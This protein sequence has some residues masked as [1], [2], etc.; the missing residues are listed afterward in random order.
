MV[1][2]TTGTATF[3]GASGQRY[4]V[5]VY[6]ADVVTTAVKFNSQGTAAATSPAYVQFGE[7]VMWYDLSLLPVSFAATTALIPTS[8][9]V[10]IPQKN[11]ST[12]DHI[13][14]IPTRAPVGVPYKAGSLIG[15]I[16]A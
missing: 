5:S 15:A 6:I 10:T 16:E 3:I 7:P 4:C 8:G 11:I 1:A 13:N 2:P 9:G 14:T 12:F